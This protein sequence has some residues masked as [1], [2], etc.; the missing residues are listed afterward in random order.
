MKDIHAASSRSLLSPM[1]LADGID[2]PL[3]GGGGNGDRDRG[4]RNAVNEA[5]SS[6]RI[7]D[8]VMQAVAVGPS[9]ELHERSAAAAAQSPVKSPRTPRAVDR[10]QGTQGHL[11][12]L[13]GGGSGS[14]G[15][16]GFG[17]RRGSVPQS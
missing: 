7:R 17:P 6:T 12:Y 2:T 5:R 16:A 15:Q 11:N 8:P 10:F 3:Q 4:S 9:S 1:R 13:N 14:D